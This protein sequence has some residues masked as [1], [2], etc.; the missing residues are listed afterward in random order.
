VIRCH[1]EGWC[2]VGPVILSLTSG[3][4]SIGGKLILHRD[5]DHK[6]L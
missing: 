1:Q 6:G 4:A 5:L 3:N 2:L